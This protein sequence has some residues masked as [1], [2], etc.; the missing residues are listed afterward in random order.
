MFGWVERNEGE[1]MDDRRIQFSPV[2]LKQN[3]GWG[4]GGMNRM[5]AAGCVPLGPTKFNLSA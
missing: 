3:G 2:W 5:Q 4:G 1:E